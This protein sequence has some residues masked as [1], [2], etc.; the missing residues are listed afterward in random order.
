MNMMLLALVPEWASN[1]LTPVWLLGVGALAGLVLLAVLW[2]LVWAATRPLGRDN[3]LRR[4]VDELPLAVREGVLLPIVVIA[5]VFA[6][7]G[8]FGAIFAHRPLELLAALPRVVTSG[9][10]QYTF[11]VPPTPR[12]DEGDVDTAQEAEVPVRFKGDEV[13]RF[14]VASNEELTI[15]LAPVQ[16]SD[17]PR[18]ELRIPA[19]GPYVWER[20]EFTYFTFGKE[21]VDKLYITNFGSQ[22]ANVTVKLVTM[23]SSPEVM[24]IPITA[25]SLL[26]VVLL[27]LLQRSLAPRLSAIALATYKSEIAQ[28][29]F[30]IILIIGLFALAISVILPY[31]T[32]GED[33]KMLKDSGFSWIMF[34]ALVQSIWAASTSVA[35][36]IEGRTALTVLSKPITR[37]S[38]VIGKFLGIFWTV[39]L[40]FIAL[41][42][43]FMVMVAYKPLYDAV[44]GSKTEPSWQLCYY[45]MAVT[46]PGLV[47]SF[48]QTLVLAAV[49]VAISTR[50]P[51]LANFVICFT[52]FVLGNLTPLLVQQS[53]QQFEIVAFFAQLIATVLPNLEVFNIQAAI[54]ADAEVPIA[55]LAYALL[56]CA[57][58][59]VIAMLLALVLFEDR[60]LA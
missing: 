41:G 30:S 25:L 34:L 24:A 57:I 60:D 19:E 9:E 53:Q 49:S 44:E 40:L 51:L 56:Y 45:E 48:M 23:T 31:N 38:F 54:A 18:P 2:G 7:F 36:E 28:P 16:P 17:T 29:L 58:Y 55:Y 27:Y 22:E 42:L 4:N 59:S 47:L 43:F 26:F 10:E 46:V 11:R 35:D 8:I 5:A 52:I 33:I 39:A 32:F 50:L 3:V 21:V 14:T 13:R 37:R 12:D 1:W 20:A 15:A 6:F